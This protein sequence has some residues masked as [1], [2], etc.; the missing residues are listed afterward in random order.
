MTRLSPL[1]LIAAVACGTPTPPVI[2]SIPTPMTD[3]PTVACDD[4]ANSP[5]HSPAEAVPLTNA[6]PNHILSFDSD[7]YFT[8]TVPPG[9]QMVATVA[10]AH[11]DTGDLDVFVVDSTGETVDASRST[12]NNE[13]VSYLNASDSAETVTLRVES[14]EPIVE[15]CVDYTISTQ[16]VTCVAD[17]AASPNHTEDD[18]AVGQEN[19]TD[20]IAVATQSDWFVLG[21]VPDGEQIQVD[22]DWTGDADLDIFLYDRD[23]EVDTLDSSFD[24]QPEVVTWIND[25]GSPVEV[26]GLVN[27]FELGSGCDVSAPYSL[28]TVIGPPTP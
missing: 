18:A 27:L 1:F 11:T 10:F 22:L 15:T 4:D 13:Y 8:V 25:T 24:D 14:Y 7:D 17:D 23:P 2:P 28:T 9:Q 19:A 20:L 21:T 16:I 3:P 26:L 5:N 6:D 12:T